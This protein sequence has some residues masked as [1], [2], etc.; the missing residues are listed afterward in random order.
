MGK[1]A[2]APVIRVRSDEATFSLNQVI[3]AQRALADACKMITGNINATVPKKRPRVYPMR[4]TAP[5]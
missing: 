2:G 5:W 4:C 1:T 3:E